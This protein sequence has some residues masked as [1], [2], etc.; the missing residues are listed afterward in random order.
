MWIIRL[1]E[2]ELRH[3]FSYGVHYF[4]RNR[5]HELVALITEGK[6][7]LKSLTTPKYSLDNI[8]EAFQMRFSNQYQSLKVGVL[9]GT[10][11]ELETVR[12]ICC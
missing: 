6:V 12:S 11:S 9:T 2:G 7:D 1:N 10:I 8:A 3:L 4:R 5:Y